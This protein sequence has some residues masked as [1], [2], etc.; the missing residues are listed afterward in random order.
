M[1]DLSRLFNGNMVTINPAITKPVII[2]VYKDE[3]DGND[4]IA[5]NVASNLRLVL[6]RWRKFS[7]NPSAL[8][9]VVPR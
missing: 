3:E 9:R 1:P 5:Y 7:C 2:T 4:D 6:D 8:Y